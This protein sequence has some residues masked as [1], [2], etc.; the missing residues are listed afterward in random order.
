MARQHMKILK[1]FHYYYHGQYLS[2]NTYQFKTLIFDYKEGTRYRK[3]EKRD[4][5]LKII[6]QKS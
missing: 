4:K 5:H 3:R 6:H 1:V 2:D